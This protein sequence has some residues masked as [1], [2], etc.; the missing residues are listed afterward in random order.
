MIFFETMI[1]SRCCLK[2]LSS[3]ICSYCTKGARVSKIS[4]SASG[5]VGG[6]RFYSADENVFRLEQFYSVVDF[7]GEIYFS[8]VRKVPKWNSVD[9]F[10]L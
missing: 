2:F 5:G 6:G 1:V 7:R 3:K 9:E 4:A 10:A 8:N